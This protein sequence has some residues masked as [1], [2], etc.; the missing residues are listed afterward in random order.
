MLETTQHQDIMIQVGLVFETPVN[1]SLLIDD[2]I[3]RTVLNSR[4]FHFGYSV[5]GIGAGEHS[6]T[7][8]VTPDITPTL[9]NF[10]IIK[11]DKLT[12][13]PEIIVPINDELLT[14]E[15]ET[16]SLPVSVANNGTV[17]H[18]VA[19]AN[20]PAIQAV[21]DAHN[22]LVKTTEQINKARREGYGE[23]GEQF[24]K[25][26]HDIDN[27]IFGEGAKLSTW[28]TDNKTVKDDNPKVR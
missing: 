24:D 13:R 27:G 1:L 7:Y 9:N 6:F 3:V 11:Y 28:Y 10:R 14:L 19:D 18:T 15:F 5:L 17:F 23:V 25:L 21:I 8:V 16:A 2:V 4:E 20:I 12:W 22:P 26:W